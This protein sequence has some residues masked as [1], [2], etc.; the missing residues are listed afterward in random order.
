LCQDFAFALLKSN[1]TAGGDESLVLTILA[2]E[3][4]SIDKI[5]HG[6]ESTAHAN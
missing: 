6:L 4:F 1:T 2:K 3:D 5:S